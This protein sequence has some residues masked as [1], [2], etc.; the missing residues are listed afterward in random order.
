MITA[1]INTGKGTAGKLVNDPTLYKQAAAGATA[2]HE[3][4]EALQHNFLLRG[5]FKN[6]GYANPEEITL[7]EVP[8]LPKE[9]AVKSFAY[10]PKNLFDK[11]DSAKL[12]NEKSLDA[13]G[14]EL[15]AD[16]G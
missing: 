6:Q 14:Q 4:A 15:G 7:H 8:Q 9:Q 16:L 10:D 5:F 11:P 2:L 12:K 3:D 1:K 13:A